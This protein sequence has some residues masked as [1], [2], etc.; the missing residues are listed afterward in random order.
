MTSARSVCRSSASRRT[1]GAVNFVVTILNMRAP[2]MS[3]FRM[4][5]F[6]WMTLV[7]SS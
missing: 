2:G 3:L 1:A 5:V 4:P 6:V 7:V